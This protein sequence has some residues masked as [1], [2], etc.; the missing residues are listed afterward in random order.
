MAMR[1][2][3]AQVR[4]LAPDAASVKAARKL[5]R[6]GPWSETGATATLVWG[7]CQGSSSTPYQVS[8]DLTGP[9]F[10][11]SCPSRK[12]PCKHA[13]ALLLL[14]V[15]T[16]G[17]V[18]EASAPADFV[19][20][21]A[22]ARA[23]RASKRAS[24]AAPSDAGP[25]DPEAAAQ[26]LAKRLTLMTDGLAD[27]QRWLF[28]L[29]RAGLAGARQQPY[30]FWDQAAARLVDAQLPG[31][32]ERVRAIPGDL[33]RRR[34]WADHLLAEA[35]RWY[36][37]TELWPQRD[38]LD[39]AD[40]GEL[41]AFLGWSWTSVEIEQGERVRDRWVVCGVHRT[42]D[43]TIQSQR[44]WL[45][46]QDTGAT[47]LVLDFAAVGGTFGVA[48]VV[49]SIVDAEVAL[50]PGHEPRRGRFVGTP[51]VIGRAGAL[52]ASGTFT[53]AHHRVAAWA[54][55]TPWRDRWPAFV[56][57]SLVRTDGD[58]LVLQ[59]ADGAGHPVVGI[60]QWEALAVTG[61]HEVQVFA[62]I[63]DGAARPLTGVLDG[64]LTPL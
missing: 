13:V 52:P 57:A 17:A 62:E 56:T 3:S 46:G 42:E 44:T 22:E 18:E 6:P 34:E 24:Q 55:H 28:D 63:E 64:V 12:F 59:D 8:V 51:A 53:D 4:E 49:G 16:D 47:V 38:Q 54:A 36:L 29:V 27:F 58:S 20:E 61:G 48:T 43:A 19:G 50:Y 35:G 30:A 10:R 33:A 11:C 14:W 21:W 32:A 37:A 5:A 39:A 15:E 26:R 2:T 45:H 31:L 7:K 1:W 40:L 23:D 41:R 9:A 25:V 60:D